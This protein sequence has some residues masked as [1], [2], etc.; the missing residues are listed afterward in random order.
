MRKLLF[1]FILIF[2]RNGLIAQPISYSYDNHGNRTQ[3]K[4]DCPNCPGSQRQI[5]TE[6]EKKAVEAETKLGLNVFPNPAQDKMQV[7]IK[8]LAAEEPA[9]ILLIDAQGKSLLTKKSDQA[10]NEVD[11]SPYKPGV[12]FIKVLVGKE[13][14]FY[15]VLK[16]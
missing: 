7:E 3:R 5:G 13:S 15:K 8:N 1:I 12:Y 4:L 11:M 2:I 9:T 14:L 10:Q 6:E 16:L